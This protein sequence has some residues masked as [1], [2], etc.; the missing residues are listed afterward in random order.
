MRI[1]ILPVES[2]WLPLL[3]ECAELM[4]LRRAMSRWEV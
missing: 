1:I 2:P 3:R 4:R